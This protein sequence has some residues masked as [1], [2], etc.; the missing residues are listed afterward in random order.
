M[1]PRFAVCFDGRLARELESYGAAPS[2][3]GNVRV[4]RPHTVLR[5]RR[6]L[7]ELLAAD[8][9]DTVICHSAWMFGLAA[10]IVARCGVRSAVWLHDRVSGRTWVE[11]WAARSTPDVVLCNSRFTAE[12][13][14]L[15]FPRRNAQVLYAPV[16]P[17]VASPAAREQRR[18]ELGASADDRVILLAGRFEPWKGHAVLLDALRGIDAPWR[19]WIAGAAQKPADA[20][21]LAGLRHQCAALHLDERVR[22]LGHRD[23]V[24]DLMAAADIHC[25][26]NTGPEPFGLA[27]VEALYAG[28]PVITSAMGGALEILDDSCGTLVPAGDRAALRSAL[29]LL[30]FDVPT[31]RRLSANGPARAARLCDPARQ[32]SALAGILSTAAAAGSR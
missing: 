11:R 6:A 18:A 31:R 25:Q 4:S 26:P 23:D 13:A 5:A 32:L 8:R 22:F 3:L 17:P 7:A 21:V 20:A 30:I 14:P 27:F 9:P 24:A 16:A 1:E 28:L 29:Q 12:S 19:L 10:P 15:M 2:R